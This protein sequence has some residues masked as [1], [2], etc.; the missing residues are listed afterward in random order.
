MAY[1]NSTPGTI[2]CNKSCR[3][4]AS[5]LAICAADITSVSTGESSKGFGVRVP[6]TTTGFKSSTFQ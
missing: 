5:V 6:V 1:E 4:V 2:C 3:F